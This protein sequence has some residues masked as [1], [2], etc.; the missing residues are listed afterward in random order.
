M[1]AVPA[2]RGTLIERRP[3]KSRQTPVKSSVAPISST[4]RQPQLSPNLR[5]KSMPLAG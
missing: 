5:K 2:R 3:R 4:T 1:E